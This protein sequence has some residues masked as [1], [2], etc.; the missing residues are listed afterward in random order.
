MKDIST[1]FKLP[2]AISLIVLL[3]FL[4]LELI[5]RRNYHEDFPIQ[6]F[7]ILWL[8]SLAF[9]LILMPLA[10]NLRAGNRISVHP[11]GL[12]LRVA[13]LI[14]LAWLWF[15]IILDQMECFLG[16]PLCD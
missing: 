8:L 4:I 7:G 11:I 14:P 6:L 2:I 1:T 12:L 15:G 5:N 13:F 16:V 10:R 3:P 9:I